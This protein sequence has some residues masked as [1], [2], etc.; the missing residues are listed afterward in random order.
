[1]F[2]M[3]AASLSAKPL[4]GLL[5]LACGCRFALTGIYEVTGLT[6]MEQPAGWLGVPLAAFALYG[7]L[8]LLLE[9]GKQRSVLP[10][11]RRGMAKTSLDG[12]L[13][14]QVRTAS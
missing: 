12:D 9:E 5:L 3:F 14:H 13:Q 1:M 4:F 11:G 8:A 6:G 2:V 10:V 7:S